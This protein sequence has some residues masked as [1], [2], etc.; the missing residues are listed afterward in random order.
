M[1]SSARTI[2]ARVY[3]FP[4]REILDPQ[5]RAIQQTLGRL[6]FEGVHEVLAGKA[7]EIEVSAEG[8]EQALRVL[9][10]MGTKL[11]SNPIMEDF[12]VEILGGTGE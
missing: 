6:G 2:R 1:S 9:N 5:G 10:D 4:R 3:V 11:L 8:R 12:E 7:F